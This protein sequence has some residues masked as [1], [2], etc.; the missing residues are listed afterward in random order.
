M[1]RRKPLR[2]PLLNF[3]FESGVVDDQ[4]TFDAWPFILPVWNSN[5]KTGRVKLVLKSQEPVSIASVP[6]QG[7]GRVAIR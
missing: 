5:K 4:N 3:R 7:K 1:L 6:E 2:A